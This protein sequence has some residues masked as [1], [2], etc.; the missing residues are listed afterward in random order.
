[1]SIYTTQVRQIC[2]SRL[3]LQSPGDGT[4]VDAAIEAGRQF[5]FDFEYPI[6]DPLY[7]PV[8]ERKI[9]MHYYTREIGAE[10]VGRWKIF[11]R[12]AMM[13]KMPYF[14]KLYAAASLTVNPLYNVDV[15]TD[16]STH[17][18]G[19][20]S[21]TKNKT[22]RQDSERNIDTD[23]TDRTVKDTSSSQTDNSSATTTTNS[24]SSGNG[25]NLFSDTPQ[26]GVNVMMN[27]GDSV[28][29]NTYL[30][31]ARHTTDN[32]SGSSSG[33]T[34]GGG[35]TETEGNSVENSVGTDNT[36]ET[37]GGSTT[38]NEEDAGESTSTEEYVE[39]VFG[40]KGNKTFGQLLAEYQKSLVSIDEMLIAQLEDLFMLV[41]E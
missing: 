18:S 38:T 36:K 39:H 8:L 23:S 27:D 9:L 11:L 3:G 21:N 15:H 37:Y 16:R 30:T 12:S 32:T 6:F 19:T 40:T 41:W 28:Q 10:T 14:N 29:N 35:T 17:G 24:Q 13:E 20:K 25:W 4:N 2:E 5:I 22:A 33:T 7:R 26:G 34:T 31:D 1:M